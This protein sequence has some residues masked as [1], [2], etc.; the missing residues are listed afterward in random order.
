MV[1][2]KQHLLRP[3]HIFMFCFVVLNVVAA[4]NNDPNQFYGVAIGCVTWAG[5]H[6]VGAIIYAN[7]Q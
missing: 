4:K 5:A 7:H 1:G 2:G 6:G 3:P